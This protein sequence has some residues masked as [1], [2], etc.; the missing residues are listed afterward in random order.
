MCAISVEFY[1]WQLE[2]VG[3]NVTWLFVGS[4][5]T[6]FKAM[7]VSRMRSAF[8]IKWALQNRQ[9]SLAEHHFAALHHTYSFNSYISCSDREIE[10]HK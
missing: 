4:A 8:V 5:V 2:H 3:Q 7:H 9:Q 10:F 6:S 1:Y